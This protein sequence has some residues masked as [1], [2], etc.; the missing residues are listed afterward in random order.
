MTANLNVDNL[1]NDGASGTPNQ[2]VSPSEGGSIKDAELLSQL[3]DRKLADALKPVL[4]EVRGVQGRQDK[5]RT[6]FREFLDEFNKQKANNP[7]MTDSDAEH[8]AERFLKEKQQ[9][10]EEKELLRKIAEKVLGSSSPGTGTPAQASIIESYKLDANDPE[11]VTEVLSKSDPKD[12]ELAALRLVNRRLQQ[13]NPSP[14]AAGTLASTP[15][16]PANVEQLTKQYQTEM[17]AAQGNP[18]LARALKAE[19]AKK[20]VPVDS[21]AFH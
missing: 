14:T 9:A 11:V 21:V 13:P 3:L 17:M 7:N 12:A 18:S 2:P 15:V 19:Y 8:A 20:G 16:R 1:E 5:D 4:A 6:A 10:Q